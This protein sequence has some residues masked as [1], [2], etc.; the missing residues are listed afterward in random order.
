MSWRRAPEVTSEPLACVEVLRN[1]QLPLRQRAASSLL[2]VY[3]HVSGLRLGGAGGPM[4][5]PVPFHK[6]FPGRHAV[7]ALV[8]LPS[9]NRI[10]VA[11][12]FPESTAELVRSLLTGDTTGARAQQLMAELRLELEPKTEV[13]SG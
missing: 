7:S 3:G 9:G 8:V 4:S 6:R 11:G 1:G 13:A 12:P 2:L 10:E 5:R